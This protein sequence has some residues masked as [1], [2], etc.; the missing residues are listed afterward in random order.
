MLS[1]MSGRGRLPAAQKPYT[2]TPK[3]P[4]SGLHDTKDRAR[5]SHVARG[6][7]L[8]PRAD[9]CC[10]LVFQNIDRQIHELNPPYNVPLPEFTSHLNSIKYYDNVSFLLLLIIK[11]ECR[12]S[13][14]SKPRP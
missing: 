12:R 6:H 5:R 8:L 10:A 1:T 2:L 11:S 4:N 7:A 3:P 14:K 9:T 13:Q